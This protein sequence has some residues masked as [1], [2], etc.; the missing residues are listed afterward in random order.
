[1]INEVKSSQPVQSSGGGES[2]ADAAEAARKA[3]AAAAEAARKAAEAAAEAAKARDAKTAQELGARAGK[4]ADAAAEA[5]RKASAAVDRM[6]AMLEKQKKQGVPPTAAQSTLLTRARLVLI[7]AKASAAKARGSAASASAAASAPRADRF[8]RTKAPAATAPAKPAPAAERMAATK[9]AQL[10][11]VDALDARA[12]AQ[13]LARV[14]AADAAATALANQKLPPDSQAVVLTKRSPQG[15]GE[16]WAKTLHGLVGPGNPAALDKH[17][18]TN[19]HT[20]DSLARSLSSSVQATAS[21]RASTPEGGPWS[22]QLYR[23]VMSALKADHPDA[24]F[25]LVAARNP[26]GKS[27]DPETDVVI[28]MTHKG[29]DGQPTTEYFSLDASGLRDRDLHLLSRVRTAVTDPARPELARGYQAAAAT[30]DKEGDFPAGLEPGESAADTFG[31]AA[32]LTGQSAFDPVLRMPV[33]QQVAV[34]RQ[35]GKDGG[36]TDQALYGGLLQRVSLKP[37]DVIIA[38]EADHLATGEPVPNALRSRVDVSGTPGLNK[39]YNFIDK[40]ADVALAP[41]FTRYTE[42]RGDAPR[43]LSGDTLTD[44]LAFALQQKPCAPPDEKLLN[45]LGKLPLMG[46]FRSLVDVEK[47]PRYSTKAQSIIKP[48]QNQLERLGGPEPKVTVVPIVYNAPEQGMVQLSLF[49]VQGQD[50]HEYLVDNTGA[51]YRGIDDWKENNKL[52]PGR[53]TYPA[54]GHLPVPGE[55]PRLVTE[56][57]RAVVDTTGE[58]VVSFLDSTALVGGVVLTGM[59]VFGTGGAAAPVAGLVIGAYSAGRSGEKLYTRAT[60]GESINPL[61]SPESRA[62]WLSVIGGAAGVGGAL[63]RPL[64]ASSKVVGA[65]GTVESAA[66]AATAADAGYQLTFDWDKL[67]PEQRLAHAQTVLFW[68]LNTASKKPAASPEATAPASVDGA[69]STGAEPLTLQPSVPV[70]DGQP[71]LQEQAPVR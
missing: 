23:P 28:A 5:A 19:Q 33:A 40:N 21:T 69:P 58:K 18:A 8:E 53:V 42:L 46:G 15:L 49:R 1:M 38:A 56:N 3:A 54:N 6:A 9:D 12:T 31:R 24:T 52:P 48:V 2:L 37:E 57:T 25:A 34:L 45:S 35:L 39:S 32:D 13:R 68:G 70:G 11:R 10:E 30:L 44:T 50:G 63:A 17:L 61:T 36:T 4:L 14:D 20:I 60:H 55:K 67:P 43:A 29:R 16:A 27:R 7:D 59:A 62:D 47:W 51:C 65:F 64:G 22:E 71:L 41:L 66:G 26:A